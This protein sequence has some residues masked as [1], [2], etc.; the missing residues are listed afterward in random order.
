MTPPPPA[1]SRRHALQRLGVLGVGAVVTACG[2]GSNG[3]DATASAT[4]SRTA[5]ATALPPTAVPTATAA[6]ATST[7]VPSPTRSATSIPE[8]PTASPTAP[9]SPPPTASPSETPTAAPSATPPATATVTP[10]QIDCILSPQQTLG[11]YFIDVG[12][13]RSD[14]REDRQGVPLSLTLRIVDVAGCAPIRDALVNVW[15]ADAA[16]VYSGFAGQPG[17]VD[18]RGQSFLRGF[19]VTDADGLVRFVTIYPG[20]YPGRTTHIHVRVHLDATTILVTQL[21]FPEPVT[22][23]VY[24]LAPYSARDQRSTTNATDS[25]YDSDVLLDIAAGGDGYVAGLVLG[26]AR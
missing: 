14:I 18:A 17:G 1:L 13:A 23:A 5:T 2:G 25:I 8:S 24:A 22:D 6:A 9:P 15:H 10:E 12:L 20:W 16:G 21:Y 26:A 4:A 19:Q 7:A 3:G 11:P